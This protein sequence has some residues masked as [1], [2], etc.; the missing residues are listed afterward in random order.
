M[1]TGEKMEQMKKDLIEWYTST[2]TRLIALME[3]SSPV[4]TIQLSPSE[5]VERFLNMTPEDWQQELYRIGVRYKGLPNEEEL[6]RTDVQ[7]FLSYIRQHL[8]RSAT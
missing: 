1:L 8:Q 4:G 2:R 6:I 3:E 7:D 5:Q